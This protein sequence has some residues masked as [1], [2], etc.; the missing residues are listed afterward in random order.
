MSLGHTT[1][2]KTGST[3][4]RAVLGRQADPR[5]RHSLFDDDLGLVLITRPRTRPDGTE[6]SPCAFQMERR[7]PL[8]ASRRV[9][10]VRHCLLTS[11]ASSSE[12]CRL[13][14]RHS[15]WSLPKSGDLVL[16]TL[17][18]TEGCSHLRPQNGGYCSSVRSF[19]SASCLVRSPRLS[20]SW[21]VLVS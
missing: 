14:S 13:R 4:N 2:R 1:D 17:G 3:S 15:S 5:P 10:S 6:T 7:M 19:P 12:L 9:R 8:W 16:E 21:I 11:Y 20:A 18:T